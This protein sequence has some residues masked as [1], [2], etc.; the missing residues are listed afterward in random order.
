MVGLF[1]GHVVAIDGGLVLADDGK[2]KKGAWLTIV[3]SG[4]LFGT[5]SR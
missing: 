3:D 4:G 1:W 2:G 5:V